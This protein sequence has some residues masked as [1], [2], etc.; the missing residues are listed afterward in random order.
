MIR[1]IS[2]REGA[3][4]P[5]SERYCGVQYIAE[6]ESGTRIVFCT[7]LYFYLVSLLTVFKI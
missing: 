7:L 3:P 2:R 1:Y 6:L 5:P 4:A